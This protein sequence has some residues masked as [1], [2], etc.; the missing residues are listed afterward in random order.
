MCV[1]VRVCVCVCVC[2]CQSGKATDR[3]VTHPRQVEEVEHS[4]VAERHSQRH[5]RCARPVQLEDEE[6]LALADVALCTQLAVRLRAVRALGTIYLVHVGR[7]REC[8]EGN[9]RWAEG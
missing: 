7:L 4:Q 1:C 2:V 8:Q 9:L 3:Q 5:S 6:G